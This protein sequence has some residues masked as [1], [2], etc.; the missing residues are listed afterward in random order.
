MKQKFYLDT[1]VFG[2][3]FDKEFDKF[4]LQL[5]ERIKLGK[6]TCLYSDL[7]EAELVKAPKNVKSH[8]YKLPNKSMEKV[9]ITD[10]ILTLAKKYIE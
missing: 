5:F 1:S 2:G 10:D 3:I 7:V 6:V 9:E 4:T 8:F